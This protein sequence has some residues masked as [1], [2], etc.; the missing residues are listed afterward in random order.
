[1]RK[2][3][4]LLPF[5]GYLVIMIHIIFGFPENNFD[6]LVGDTLKPFYYSFFLLISISFLISKLSKT[7][8]RSICC[9]LFYLFQHFYI[10]MAFQKIIVMSRGMY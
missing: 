7:N 4:F 1:M 2:N 5:L 10:F 6:P 8:L 9:C 3:F